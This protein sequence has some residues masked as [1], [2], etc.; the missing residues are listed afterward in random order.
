MIPRAFLY[1]SLSWYMFELNYKKSQQIL[2][3]ALMERCISLACKM[4]DSF[5][6]DDSK[7][8]ER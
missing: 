5:F 2:N 1:M 4:V 8:L 3:A 6:G 7:M